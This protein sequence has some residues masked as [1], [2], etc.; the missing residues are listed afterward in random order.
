MIMGGAHASA[1]ALLQVM[2]VDYAAGVRYEE[3]G[4]GLPET[5][6]GTHLAALRLPEMK[7]HLE[8]GR[9]LDAN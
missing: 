8:D 2:C 9:V 6:L 1:T 7:V 5:A 3:R 4:L